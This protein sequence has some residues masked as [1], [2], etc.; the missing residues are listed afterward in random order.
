MRSLVGDHVREH[1]HSLT[2][3]PEKIEPETIYL[4]DMTEKEKNILD[5]IES[6]ESKIELE[7]LLKVEPKVYQKEP[8]RRVR[9]IR[10]KK[11][12]LTPESSQE[13]PK[14]TPSSHKIKS[15]YD[16]AVEFLSKVN[17][18]E[19]SNI[20]PEEHRESVCKPDFDL[21][22]KEAKFPFTPA[23]M[24]FAICAQYYPKL[25]KDEFIEKYRA[26]R[27]LIECSA[28]NT[29]IIMP[30]KEGR[31]RP[32]SSDSTVSLE[33]VNSK[34]KNKGLNKL[35]AKIEQFQEDLAKNTMPLLHTNTS[36]GV[37]VKR[38][39]NYHD[40]F[41]SSL[42]FLRTYMVKKTKDLLIGASNEHKLNA[43]RQMKLDNMIRLMENDL[44]DLESVQRGLLDTLTDSFQ[45]EVKV[46]ED[47]DTNDTNSGY[48]DKNL[49]QASHEEDLYL[50]YI[51]YKKQ[52]AFTQHFPKDNKPEFSHS[53]R[54]GAVNSIQNLKQEDHVC[55]ICNDGDYTDSN[56]IVY[57]SRC[58]VCCHQQ[59]YGLPYVPEG[60]WVC[61]LCK[62]YGPAGRS[63]MCSLCP[64]RGGCM[65]RIDIASTSECWRRLSPVYFNYMKQ[66]KCE[67]KQESEKLYK[68]G[69]AFLADD[70]VIDSNNYK[71]YLYYD[72]FD[73]DNT[74]SQ[75]LL[76]T[77]M[78]SPRPFKSWI[79]ISCLKKIPYGNNVITSGF[80]MNK[81]VAKG[82]TIRE[83]DNDNLVNQS[84]LRICIEQ[85]TYDNIGASTTQRKIVQSF[86]ERSH[87]QNLKLPILGVSVQKLSSMISKLLEQQ[88]PI[89]TSKV[90]ET[91]HPDTNVS[92]R[93]SVSSMANINEPVNDTSKMKG[94]NVLGLL[95]NGMIKQS[96][97]SSSVAG[98]GRDLCSSMP[99]SQPSHSRSFRDL[100]N[101]SE[102]YKHSSSSKPPPTSNIDHQT[103][104]DLQKDEKTGHKA[105]YMS[106]ACERVNPKDKSINANI[107]SLCGVAGF[108]LVKCTSCSVRFH[109]ECA[110]ICKIRHEDDKLYCNRHLGAMIRKK[111]V[112]DRVKEQCEIR[113]WANVKRTGRDESKFV[114]NLLVPEEISK[115][116]KQLAEKLEARSNQKSQAD[117]KEEIA[118]I[119]L[120]SIIEN[121]RAKQIKKSSHQQ[122]KLTFK[123]EN[124]PIKLEFYRDEH[125][126]DDKKKLSTRKDKS[127]LK[128]ILDVPIPIKAEKKD[129][130]SKFKAKLQVKHTQNVKAKKVNMRRIVKAE[131]GTLKIEST[132]VSEFKSD[133]N[134]KE[135]EIP[136]QLEDSSGLVPEQ[137][138]VEPESNL[139]IEFQEK[140]EE[141]ERKIKTFRR[142]KKG[143]KQ[144]DNHK[145]KKSESKSISSVEE[146][147]KI[148]KKLT[149]DEFMKQVKE[150]YE[151]KSNLGHVI[152]IFY[153]LEKPFNVIYD[154]PNQE[155]KPENISNIDGLW[156]Q[157]ARI[158]G[159]TLGRCYKRLQNI[160]AKRNKKIKKPSGDNL[161]AATDQPAPDK[162]AI[163]EE[164][165]D[166]LAKDD[167]TLY[168][169]C[170]VPFEEGF[171]M[172]A[173][174]ICEDWFHH[175]C[176]GLD[177]MTE[178]Q[179]KEASFLCETCR[180]LKDADARES[181]GVLGKRSAFKDACDVLGENGDGLCGRSKEAVRCS[182]V[183]T[184]ARNDDGNEDESDDGI[185]KA[186]N[187]FGSK[188]RQAEL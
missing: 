122:T 103:V 3:S 106:M 24:W 161:M 146:S 154:E 152:T 85:K 76:I 187:K 6:S 69:D 50:D 44:R 43:L 134:T 117:L 109:A 41:N 128:T 119:K 64:R 165:Q 124:T 91:N 151:L 133:P 17:D 65:R 62:Y 46:L 26:A 35:S 116:A 38:V 89:Q 12:Q 45:T 94:M 115:T 2:R 78:E 87:P 72:Y 168:C 5:Q 153:K 184:P 188:K 95:E 40:E 100:T 84:E 7:T 140:D 36:K 112:G 8:P 173:C 59:C 185:K 80:N 53:P 58:S 142:L 47:L 172:V 130:I 182:Q 18:Q 19:W 144:K 77:S 177:H 125:H 170:K 136:I 114:A 162:Q 148:R 31:K 126:G 51:E 157:M 113:K 63:M 68:E 25:S 107:C 127:K 121:N 56:L 82:K 97:H 181:E 129:T 178:D 179:I 33:D 164:I 10:T 55:Q 57:C 88:R 183:R 93:F 27:E 42:L 75:R 71:T 66:E 96:E 104:K 37:G 23:C 169:I 137:S 176:V 60:N 61:E 158:T 13:K 159:Y 22:S 9:E 67:S 102:I 90:L 39:K 32:V 4:D 156:N 132:H 83:S 70:V 131:E 74:D 11:T 92:K 54:K 123:T 48:L 160:L 149:D 16:Q 167:D 28:G 14:N 139:K 73:A 81:K 155:F 34:Q 175:T 21:D 147:S 145:D 108:M 105:S 138:A 98:S 150:F 79:H 15:E 1:V 118:R 186:F 120:E 135:E 174:D 99:K 141:S 163:V 111:V 110:R 143:L 29:T 52:F 166:E 20:D 49:R 180:H 171:L 101:T 86:K 30:A